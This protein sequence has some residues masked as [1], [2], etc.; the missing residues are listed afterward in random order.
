MEE[1]LYTVLVV[2][3]EAGVADLYRSWVFDEWQVR[4]GTNVA[5]ALSKLDES[6]DLIVLDRRLPDGSGDE[7]LDALEALE[8]EP[9]V[10]AMTAV[11]P[12]FDIVKLPVDDYLVKPL[13]RETFRD[14]L[15][16]LADRITYTAELRELY[17]LASKKAV[18]EARKPSTELA[19]SDAYADLTERVESKRDQADEVLERVAADGYRPVFRGL[20]QRRPS[21][22]ID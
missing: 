20:F 17:A 19:E 13:S 18:L 15:Q 5:E 14:S 16:R 7:V 4:V 1:G 12:D 6:I 2:E 10:V 11:E 3:D 22:V 8:Y 21:A 9:L